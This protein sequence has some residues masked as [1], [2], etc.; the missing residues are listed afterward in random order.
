MTQCDG[1][2]IFIRDIIEK[3]MQSAAPGF[4][5]PS[6]LPLDGVKAVV[7]QVEKN[8]EQIE[9]EGIKLANKSA[10]SFFLMKH[11]DSLDA[12]MTA[13]RETLTSLSGVDVE[14]ETREETELSSCIF[15]ARVAEYDPKYED[16]FDRF[17]R[18][19]NQPALSVFLTWSMKFA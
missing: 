1:N 15:W 19:L 3:R 12:I 9:S 14:L 13:A 8:V 2:V 10:T 11:I 6:Q 4:S 16:I 7:Y 18:E 5:L 17:A